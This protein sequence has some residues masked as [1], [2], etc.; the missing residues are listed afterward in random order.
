MLSTFRYPG[1]VLPTWNW[2]KQNRLKIPRR[3]MSSVTQTVSFF[4][5]LKIQSLR[6]CEV[7]ILLF[8]RRKGTEEVPQPEETSAPG[9]IGEGPRRLGNFPGRA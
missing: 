7:K 3:R 1:E 9:E 8:S 6:A 5:S 4:F 2:Q